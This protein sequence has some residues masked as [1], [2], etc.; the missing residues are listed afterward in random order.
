MT[1]EEVM[2]KLQTVFDTVFVEPVVVSETLCADDVEEWDSLVHVAFIVA[3]ERAFNIRF[4]LGET[5]ATANVG[6]FADL[7]LR[8]LTA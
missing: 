5:E 6:E 8:R 4:R 2:A 7:I 1:K 3:V